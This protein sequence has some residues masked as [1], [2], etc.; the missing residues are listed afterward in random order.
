ME[1]RDAQRLLKGNGTTFSPAEWSILKTVL[2]SERAPDLPTF[3]AHCEHDAGRV[4]KLLTGN[5]LCSWTRYA[6]PS[7]LDTPEDVRKVLNRAADYE[8]AACAQRKAALYEL[9]RMAGERGDQPIIIKGAANA[10]AFYEKESLRPSGDVDVFLPDEAIGYYVPAPAAT[11]EET[12]SHAPVAYHLPVFRV[13]GY[14]VELHRF[15]LSESQWGSYEDLAEGSLPLKGFVNLRRP[16]VRAAF[17]IAL[18]HFARHIGGFTFDLL[19]MLNLSRADGFDI[20][21]AAALW[22]EKGLV[23]LV[24]PGLTVL[25]TLTPVVSD[26]T[27]RA[28]FDSLSRRKRREVLVGLRLLSGRRLVKLRREWFGSRL[29]RG[30]F[31]ERLTQRFLG[32]TAATQHL[33]GLSPKRPLFWFLHC[34]G[35]PLKRVLVFWK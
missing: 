34:V 14:P 33:T 1:K 17:T 5:A 26:A 21:Q 3:A 32:S 24:L 19:D 23:D 27:W 13:A 30:R 8:F 18:L 22:R 25:D 15:F 7:F 20:E 6:C 2:M 29:A 16:D 35:L 11:A 12:V 9:D 28:L 31:I 10:L 4:V